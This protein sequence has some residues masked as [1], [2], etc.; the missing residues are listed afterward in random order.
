MLGTSLLCSIFASAT[1]GLGLVVGTA[2]SLLNP[3]R[4]VTRFSAVSLSK[5]SPYNP[6]SAIISNASP[7]VVAFDAGADRTNLLPPSFQNA[8]SRMKLTSSTF[9]SS[10][11]A[12]PLPATSAERCRRKDCRYRRSSQFVLAPRTEVRRMREL[13][14]GKARYGESRCGICDI[15]MLVLVVRRSESGR[16]L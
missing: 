9:T 14:E 1:L 6:T 12:P 11:S 13:S 7:P 4:K 3:S 10:F 16:G 8:Q 15:L 2:N 5:S